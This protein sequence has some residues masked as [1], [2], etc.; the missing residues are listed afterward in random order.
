MPPD[1]AGKHRDPKQ[2]RLC[3]QDGLARTDSATDGRPAPL[4]VGTAIE[5][6]IDWAC[7]PAGVSVLRKPPEHTLG[8]HAL[9]GSADIIERASMAYRVP[10]RHIRQFGHEF[11]D[12]FDEHRHHSGGHGVLGAFADRRSRLHQ[13]DHP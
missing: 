5:I 7:R 13:L 9:G 12:L 11:Q 4:T 8:D 1:S 2:H 10:G 6:M 3:E